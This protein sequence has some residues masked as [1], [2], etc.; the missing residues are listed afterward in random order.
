MLK[1]KK[2]MDKNDILVEV[3]YKANS[4]TRR[5]K[6]HYYMDQMDCDSDCTKLFKPS[7]YQSQHT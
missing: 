1:I 7:Y 6:P 5:D 4:C 2:I 3:Q